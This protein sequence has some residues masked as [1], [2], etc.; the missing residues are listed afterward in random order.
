MSVCMGSTRGSSV[1]SSACGVLESVVRGIGGVC[2]MCMC[3]AWGGVG[4]VGGRGLGLDFT[5]PG[6]TWGKWD[7]CLCFGCRGVV[8]VVLFACICRTWICH[9]IS[10]FYEEHSAGPHD[11]LAKKKW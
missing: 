5:N 8:W 10:R 4:D 11:W 7:M 3:L 9:D 2:H 1:F 6:G